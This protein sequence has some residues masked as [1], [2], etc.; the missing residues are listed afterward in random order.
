[1]VPQLGEVLWIVDLNRQSLDRVVPDIAAGRIAAMFEAAGWQTITVKYGRRLRELFERDG[2]RGAAPADR[3]D[4]QRG[5]PAAAAR[6]PPTSCASGCPAAGRGARERR[7]ADRASSTTTSCC[8]RSATSAATTSATCSTPSRE[9]D[10]VDRPA[11]G[12]SS[13]TRSRRGACRP[14]AIPATTRRCSPPSSG[15]SSPASSAPTP[16]TRGRRSRRVSAEAE[17]CARG[18]A[19]GC[20][21]SRS[22]PR[23]PPAVAGRARP[24]APR[25]RV[26]PAG[27]RPLLRRPR[28]RRARGRART[29]SRSAPTS[30]RRPTSAAGST[31]SGSGTSG[32]RI[33]WFADDTD[34]LVRWRESEHGQH[35]ELGIAEGNLVGLLGELGRDLVARRAAAAADRHAVRPVRQPR[36]RAV[37]VRHLRGRP[38]DPGRH[39]VGRHARAR[40]R[41]APVDHHA[42]GR[43][44]AAAL[45]RLGAGLRPGPRVDAAAR[46]RRSSGGPDG[47][48]GLL[49]AH[50]RGRSTRRSPRVPDDPDERERAPARRRSPAATA[51]R[52]PT[53][54]RR[55]DAGRRRRGHARGR[56]P[57]PTSSTAAG[58]RVRRRLPHLGRPGLPRAAGAPGPAPTATTRSSTRCSRPTRAAPIVTVLD[59]HPHTLS[60]L[61]GVRGDADRVPRRRRLRPVGRRRGPLPP[62]RH[63]R[64]HDRRRRPR[65]ARRHARHDRHHDA[66]AVR[67]DG[68][69]HDP[70]AGSKRDGERVAAGEELVEIE[71]DKATM[72][73]RR[74]GR[75]MLEIV[76]AEGDDRSRSAR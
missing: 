56:S 40:G 49:P 30:R 26:D 13:P 76:A 61:A 50:A 69:G 36:A 14:R 58:H 32:E 18:R 6:R 72:T 3:R 15:S 5:V 47:D 46:A 68:G 41:R 67:L 1:M 9:A 44:R 22:T 12:R 21:A 62:L 4:D 25:P 37:V 57:P 2:R 35:I 7:A 74:R 54:A 42:V 20:A 27:V 53:P 65:P 29:S 43:A 66:A 19:S 31:G 59:G 39:A 28:A 38:V 17:L 60:F 63:R 48:L 55:G 34:T 10:A 45:H 51:L 52:A 23:R 71:T 73:L 70:H 64:R 8:A 24:R 16:T 33:D 11:V 75:G